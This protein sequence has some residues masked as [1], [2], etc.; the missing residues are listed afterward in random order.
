MTLF[1]NFCLQGEEKKGQVLE[2]NTFLGMT[3]QKNVAL[4]CILTQW[5]RQK[6]IT[7]MLRFFKQCQLI[8]FC[9]KKGVCRKPLISKRRFLTLSTYLRI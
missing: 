2:D 9:A 8:Q 3:H 7:W 5:K 6:S 4:R 1:E